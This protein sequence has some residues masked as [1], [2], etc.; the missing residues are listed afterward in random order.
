MA[1]A[2][3]FGRG[4]GLG[5]GSTSGILWLESVVG[6]KSMRDFSVTSD[7]VSTEGPAEVDDGA[8]VGL[9]AP[10]GIIELSLTV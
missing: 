1:T 9:S 5:F 2:G 8:G 3:G 10:V 4:F 7:E 6:P